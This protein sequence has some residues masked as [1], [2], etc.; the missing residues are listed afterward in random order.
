MGMFSWRSCVSGHDIMNMYNKL[1]EGITVVLPNNKVLTGTYDGYGRVV[2][3]EKAINIF[4]E[5]AY[6]MYGK[7]D[8]NLI[9]EAETYDVAEKLIKA[10]LPS[11]YEE[12]MSFDDLKLSENAEGQGHWFS[13]YETRI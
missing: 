1:H 8:S 10:M 5:L 13:S 6:C 7:A 2:T 4:D 12:N 9:S 11:E 3:E